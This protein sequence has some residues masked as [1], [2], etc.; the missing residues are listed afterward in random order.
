MFYYWLFLSL[1]LFMWAGWFVL[2]RVMAFRVKV[3]AQSES[4][5]SRLSHLLPLLIAGYLLTLRVPIPFLNDRFVALAIW[6]AALGAALT[7][8]GLLFCVWARF[9]LAGNWSGFVQVKQDHELIVDGPYRWVRHPI[10]T[11]LLLMFL[12]TALAVGEWRGVLAVAIAAIAFWYKL[13]LEETV[14]RGAFGESYVRYAERVPALIPYL[15]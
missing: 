1:F 3:T 14:M 13:R 15:L 11:G 4:V 7:F 6:P 10:Y 2:W 9:V 12:G 5:P 8:A